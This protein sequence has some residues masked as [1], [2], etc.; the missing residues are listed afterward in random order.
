MDLR[1]LHTAAPTVDD[2][3]LAH[4]GR[5]RGFEV[6]LHD[7]PGLPG[8]KEMQV[9]RILDRDLDGIRERTLA[10]GQVRFRQAEAD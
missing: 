1:A 5:L 4:P 7:G 2:A 6:G 9:D 3:N 10:V 8:S